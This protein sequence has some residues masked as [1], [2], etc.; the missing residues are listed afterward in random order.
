L[1][2]ATP[3]TAQA[4]DL[5]GDE[6]FYTEDVEDNSEVY[7]PFESVNRFTFKFNDFVLSNT[8][9][10]LTNVYTAITPD[11]VE[12]GANNFF[13]NLRYPVRLASNLLQCRFKGAW[14]ETGRF[15]INSTVGIVGIFTP[16][17]VYECF[18]PIKSEDVG[19]VFG[20]WGIGEGPYLM[21]P[22]LGPSNLRDLAGI[23]GDR[24]FSPLNEPFSEI[25]D[26]NWEW[27][28]ALSSTDYIARSPQI[29]ER[30]K[31]LKGSSIDPYSSLRNGY[32]KYRRGAVAE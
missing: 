27:Q 30:Y 5:A 2:A 24:A 7:D 4:Q 29:I 26:W 20:A 10:P 25:S 12:K 13:Y 9:Q 17:D 19:Q 3:L 14:V 23:F 15:A 8:I 32:T 6:E 31:L 21:L 28:F 16:A 18:A 11:P 22:F 1:F